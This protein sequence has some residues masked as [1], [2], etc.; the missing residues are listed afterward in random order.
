MTVFGTTSWVE[1]CATGAAGT[2]PFLTTLFLTTG[3]FSTTFSTF[4]LFGDTFSTIFSTSSVTGMT[5]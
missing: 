3:T 1:F 2:T 5:S 4:P